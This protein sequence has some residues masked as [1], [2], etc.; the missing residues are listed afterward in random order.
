MEEEA[1]FEVAD[2]VP[3]RALVKTIP[4]ISVLLNAP[5]VILTDK[6]LERYVFLNLT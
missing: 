3:I 2:D 5:K 1:E 6:G 4:A